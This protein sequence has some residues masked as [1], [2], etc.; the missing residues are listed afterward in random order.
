MNQKKACVVLLFCLRVLGVVGGCHNNGAFVIGL[1]W[2]YSY[3][4]ARGLFAF[5]V[6]SSHVR[7][8]ASAQMI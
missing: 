2:G 5:Q 7:T 3:L 8:I 1:D 4:C 6:S